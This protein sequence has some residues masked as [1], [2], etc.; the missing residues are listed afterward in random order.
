MKKK[1]LFI[2][3]AMVMLFVALLPINI[4]ADETGTTSPSNEGYVYSEWASAN[5]SYAQDDIYSV[6]TH[7]TSD[8]NDFYGFS[9]TFPDSN[10]IIINGIE[11]CFDAFNSKAGGQTIEV[12]LSWNQGSS[13]T[14]SK[15]TDGIGLVDDD[16]YHCVGGSSDTWGRT[17]TAQ[18]LSSSNF[19]VYAKF[20]GSCDHI[21]ANVNYTIP[22]EPPSSGSASGNSIWGNCSCMW[23]NDSGSGSTWFNMGWAF[24]DTITA[25]ALRNMFNNSNAVES[26]A[27]WN[28]VSQ[29]YW[30]Y[31]PGYPAFDFTIYRFQAVWIE[32]S[33]DV[34]ICF[35][36]NTTECGSCNS[37]AITTFQNQ[38]NV[39]GTLEY[40]YN[41][42]TGYKVWANYSS[43]ITLHENIIN[44][45]GTHEYRWT[46]IGDWEIWANYTGNASSCPDTNSGI[47]LYSNIINATGT[48]EYS[49][50][51]GIYTVWANYTGNTSG[52]GGCPDY[53]FNYSDDNITISV[54][55]N[56]S[57]QSNSSSYSVNED[58]WLFISG[59]SIEAGELGILFVFL[60]FSIAFYIDREEKKNIWKP[61]LFFLDV[62]IALATGIFYMTNVQYSVHWWIGIFMFMFAVIL[63]M[64]GLY[65]GLHFGRRQ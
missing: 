35:Y 45:T 56:C 37:T 7:V 8:E 53:W 65:Y 39:T 57:S 31:L 38:E 44:A 27:I 47:T 18:E 17:W 19:T 25:S 52:C 2:A 60:L 50:N 48:L 21:Y 33:N 64:S 46:Q 26:I 54:F 58:N 1:K 49:N 9:F 63:A 41:P 11:V 23:L 20:L 62:P 22:N 24:C 3:M 28:P 43:S 40:T 51:S 13:W 34:N 16:G 61:I 15:Y 42:T 14:S 36:D 55:V 6:A 12:K 32:V 59:F 30:F 10:Q 29:G 5:N 4:E